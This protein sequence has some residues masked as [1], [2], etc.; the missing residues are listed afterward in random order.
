MRVHRRG[1]D[2]LAYFVGLDNHKPSLGGG[3]VAVSVCLTFDMSGL[4]RPQAGEAAFH[5]RISPLVGLDAH[6]PWAAKNF[7]IS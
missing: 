6:M 1:E 7:F 5:G 2:I 3:P 4:R